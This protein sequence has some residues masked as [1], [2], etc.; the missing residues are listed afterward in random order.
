MLLYV[1]TPQFFKYVS[2]FFSI[3]YK[4]INFAII[5]SELIINAILSSVLIHE[6]IS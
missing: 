3:I 1:N 6:N 5:N 2:S 4:R